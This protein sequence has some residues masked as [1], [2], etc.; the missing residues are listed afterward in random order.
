MRAERGILSKLLVI[1]YV[2]CGVQGKVFTDAEPSCTTPV[3]SFCAFFV[4]KLH[5]E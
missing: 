1:L 2:L 3:T 5:A 4:L